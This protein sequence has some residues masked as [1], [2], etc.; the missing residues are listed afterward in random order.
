[1]LSATVPDRSY[2]VSYRYQ[3]YIRLV[4]P[5]AVICCCCYNWDFK[6]EDAAPNPKGRVNIVISRSMAVGMQWWLNASQWNTYWVC[7]RINYKTAAIRHST[8][9]ILHRSRQEHRKADYSYFKFQKTTISVLP[10]KCQ[11]TLMA[12]YLNCRRLSKDSE[13]ETA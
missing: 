10:A 1:M 3:T 4:S 6:C 11:S 8:I 2:S 5:S 13:I 9:I 7:L 12:C